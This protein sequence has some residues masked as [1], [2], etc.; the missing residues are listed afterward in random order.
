M[1]VLG[2]AVGVE[3]AARASGHNIAVAFVPGRVDATQAQTDVKGFAVLEPVADG[4]RNYRR[5]LMRSHRKNFC[6]TRR[7]S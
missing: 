3:Q 4:F 6:S 2:G 1:I 5:R 7:N